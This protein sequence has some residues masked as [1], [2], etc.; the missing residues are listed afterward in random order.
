MVGYEIKHALYLISIICLL[1]GCVVAKS[2]HTQVVV[3]D[4]ASLL[5]FLA[6]L[7]RKAVVDGW[8]H[9]RIERREVFDW[10]LF[11]VVLVGIHALAFF[12]GFV[13]GDMSRI[14]P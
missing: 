9:I 8:S 14:E 13:N 1:L 12:P 4:I 7:T 6:W 2:L 3:I 11:L 10:L 5:F